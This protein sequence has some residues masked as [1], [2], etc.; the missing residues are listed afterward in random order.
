M[1]KK[2]YF[3]DSVEKSDGSYN[4]IYGV[5]DVNA[6]V[7]NLVG[8]G[9]A[10]FPS[11][12]T[13][14]VSELNSLT[15]ALVGEG[16]SFDGLKVSFIE[17]KI[18][19]A[20]GIGYFENGAT[21]VVDG[22]GEELEYNVAETLY[23][24]AEY[25]QALNTCG[26]CA[27]ESEPSKGNG[28]YTIML[29]TIV[30]DGIVTDKRTVAQSKVASMGR[31]VFERLY[32]LDS[33]GTVL[34]PLDMVLYDKEIDLSKFNYIVS[35]WKHNNTMY[36]RLPVELLFG[37]ESV[38]IVNGFGGP[39]VTVQFIDGRLQLRT[40]SNGYQLSIHCSVGTEIFL[41]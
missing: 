31:N 11:K 34:L 18:H 12:D 20:Q 8:A 32:A 6:V 4:N 16:T 28:I 9:V 15:S 33:G 41:C 22:D 30:A 1:G 14:E 36:E 27:S 35:V 37:G 40:N 25:N 26:F 3:L 2:V 24:Y 13:Y 29:A 39:T 23:V 10:P 21:I 17:G 38:K 7:N 5:D 19:I